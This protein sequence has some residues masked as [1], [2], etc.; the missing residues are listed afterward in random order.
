M[1]SPALLVARR[2]I[3]ERS[4]IV[5]TVITLLLVALAIV[6]PT[7]LGAGWPDRYTV[8]A[9][10]PAGL[11]VARAAARIAAAFHARVKIAAHASV[12]VTGGAIHARK[13][14]DDKLVGLL[15]QA[16]RALAASRPA[17]AALVPLAA[18]I[19]RGAVLQTGSAVKLRQTRR[20]AQG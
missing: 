10:D 6:L 14:P 9:G 8:A 1:T 4:F 20:S 2:K 18:R 19:Y 12:T 7:V 17:A 5:S 15:Q 13:A 3:T 11:R 16:N